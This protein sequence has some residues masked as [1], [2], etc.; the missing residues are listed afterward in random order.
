MKEHKR[1]VIDLGRTLND[2]RK[3]GNNPHLA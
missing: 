1:I 2:A 3:S